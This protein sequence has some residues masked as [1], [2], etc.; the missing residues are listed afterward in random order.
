LKSLLV[1]TSNSG[2]LKEF[3]GLL[4]SKFICESLPPQTPVVVEDGK[5]YRENALKKAKGYFEIFRKP[6]LSDD[7]G[8]EIDILKG[9]PG[10]DSAIYGGEDLAWPE[11]WKFL[12][13]ELDKI[14]AINPTAR[15]RCVL[16]YYDGVNPPQFFEATTEGHI[17]THPKGNQGFGYDPIFYS[18]ELKKTL[19]VASAEE[20]AKVS[21][22]ARA[23]RKFLS[24]INNNDS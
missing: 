14:K 24:W 16:C 18:S 20:K 1:A 3:N 11:R 2:K 5:T 17:S 4:N 7:S 9:A 19:G 6:I 22:R 12:Y 13:D 15:F 21:H 8:L 23:V 10:V